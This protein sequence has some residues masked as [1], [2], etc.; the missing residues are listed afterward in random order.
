MRIFVTGGS[1]HLG[2]VLVDYLQKDHEVLAPDSITCNILDT[3]QLKKII[4]DFQPD[5]VI[6]L[7]AYVDT[8]G[9][10]ENIEKALDVNV[11]G[12]LNLVEICLGLDCKFVYVSS[13]YVFGGE[14][15]N[16]T[17]K[18]RLNPIN[19]YGKTKSAAEYIVSVL[20]NYQIIRAPFIKQIYSE[21]FTDQYCS[22]HFLDDL[23]EKLVR[24][25]F[26]N[27]D[28]I[29]HIA[30][31]RASLYDIYQNKGIDAKPI[32]VDKK[33]YGIIPFDTSLIDNS[34]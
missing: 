11:L 7:A 2:K 4:H 12:T 8:F 28:N 5:I 21:V 22:R 30:T 20:P 34:L 31:E 27:E 6:H 14:K 19:I 26:I 16:Y 18:D 24:N 1:G 9:C 13:E 10:E 15:G 33:Y 17:V 29:V 25:I 32:T 23:C 3:F